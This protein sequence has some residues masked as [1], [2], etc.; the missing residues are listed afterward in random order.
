MAQ[1]GVGQMRCEGSAGAGAAPGAQDFEHVCGRGV[2]PEG[3]T[4]L[5]TLNHIAQRAKHLAG[6]GNA[7]GAGDTEMDTFL[8]EVGFAIIVGKGKL[9][10]RGRKE[11]LRVDSPLDLGELMLAYADLVKEKTLRVAA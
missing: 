3:S 1:V 9:S 7:L 11:T 4:N 10:F 2:P 8:S 5:R 6:N